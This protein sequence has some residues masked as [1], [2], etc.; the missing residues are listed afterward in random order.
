VDGLYEELLPRGVVKPDEQLATMSHGL[1]QFSV[2]D[3]DGNRI[4]FAEPV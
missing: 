3:P 4:T 1:R 2:L